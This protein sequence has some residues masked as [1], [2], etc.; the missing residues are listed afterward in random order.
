MNG[1]L[2]NLLSFVIKR[3][4]DAKLFEHIRDM[5]IAQVDTK[6][7]GE[8]KRAAVKKELDELT[9]DLYDSVKS[10]APYLI[11]LAIETAVALVKK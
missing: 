3:L 5:V 8:Q 10:T 6:L 4:V 9:G 2:L 11:N 1:F 7:T